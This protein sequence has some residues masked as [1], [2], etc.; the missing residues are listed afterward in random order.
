MNPP[1]V[2]RCHGCSTF[3]RPAAAPANVGA[4]REH[5]ETEPQ[6]AATD[7]PVIGPVLV[8]WSRMGFA[9]A[10]CICLED[11]IVMVPQPW[12]LGMAPF[13]LLVGAVGF[14]MLVILLAIGPNNPLGGVIVVGSLAS[15]VGLF[16]HRRRVERDFRRELSGAP[17]ERLAHRP[18]A[19]KLDLADIRSLKASSFSLLVVREGYEDVTVG[20]PIGSAEAIASAMSKAYPGV[21]SQER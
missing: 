2:V 19:M 1:S 3:S 16:M 13:R 10:Y 5:A 18:E 14:A 21:W 8:Q 11:A 7:R 20:V 17:A 6:P 12:V 9:R 4:Y 15:F